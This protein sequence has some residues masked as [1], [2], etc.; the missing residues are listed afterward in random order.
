MA[1]LTLTR[2]H[3]LV[4]ALSVSVCAQAADAVRFPSSAPLFALTLS[5]AVDGQ[6]FALASLQGRPLVINFWARVCQPCRKEIPHL[7]TLQARYR[8]SRLEVVGIAVEESDN[9]ANVR[10]FAQA[11]EMSYLSLIGGVSPGIELMRALGNSKAGLPFTVVID[12]AGTIRSSKLGE[13]TQ[14]E[15]E[16]AMRLVL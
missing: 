4:S 10:E 15:M 1:R 6:P 9:R 7:A 5:R 16:T 11:Y 8:S 14:P 12:R 13:M 2:F 3:C